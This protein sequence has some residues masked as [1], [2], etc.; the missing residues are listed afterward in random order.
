DDKTGLGKEIA[1]ELEN[2]DIRVELIPGDLF[3]DTDR[4][5]E[6][7]N[8]VGGLIITP[9]VDLLTDKFNQKTIWNEKDEQFLK[10]SFIAANLAAKDIIHSASNGGGLFVTITRL[11]GCFGF[12]GQGVLHPL[13]GGLAGLVKTASM[14]WEKVCCHAIDIAPA[15]KD[16]KEAAIAAANEILTPGPIEVGLDKKSRC[17]L[18]LAPSPPPE[19]KTMKKMW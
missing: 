2:R 14:E 17:L 4:L 19:G 7:L 3:A 18:M 1:G 12:S 11:D 10:N 6:K 16:N 13:Q 5:K 8:D 9:D 15:W